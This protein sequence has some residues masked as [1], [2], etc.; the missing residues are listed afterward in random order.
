[1]ENALVER[2]AWSRQGSGRPCIGTMRVDDGG[3]ELAGRDPVSG[4]EVSLSIPLTEVEEVHTGSPGDRCVV[5]E[6]AASEPILLRWIGTARIGAGPPRTNLLAGRL[7]AL[8]R[9]AHLPAAQG[10]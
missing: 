6:L 2:I 3:I 7:A 10:G 1:M 9:A 8:A 5:L 4:V